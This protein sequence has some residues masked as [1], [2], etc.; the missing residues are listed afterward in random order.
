MPRKVTSEIDAAP[1]TVK[2]TVNGAARSTEMI[3]LE[4]EATSRELA[5]NE[6]LAA[7][8]AA[9]RTLARQVAARLGVLFRGQ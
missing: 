5:S 7:E 4:T 3:S 9:V 1:V 6:E 2:S 8:L